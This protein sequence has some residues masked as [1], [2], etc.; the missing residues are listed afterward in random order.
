MGV[1]QNVGISMTALRCKS[2]QRGTEHHRHE[3]DHHEKREQH[4]KKWS[5]TDEEAFV[6]NQTFSMSGLQ[7][8]ILSLELC[9]EIHGLGCRVTGQ[10]LRFSSLVK[11]KEDFARLLTW[12]TIQNPKTAKTSSLTRLL[13]A[14]AAMACEPASLSEPASAGFGFW[15]KAAKG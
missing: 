1:L 3:V 5:Q 4:P 14:L 8:S 10:R 12:P 6:G 9:L 7:V 13:P 11:A 2:L 15:V